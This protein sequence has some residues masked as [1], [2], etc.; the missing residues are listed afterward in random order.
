MPR[1]SDAV[2]AALSGISGILVTPFD[3]QDRPAPSRLK[4][5]VD[6]AIAAGVQ[7][8][9][10]NGNT[11]E[12]Y[13]L[14]TAEAETM[15]HA[16]AE[17][18]GGRVPL[19]AGVGRA[20]P[21]ALALAR[22]SAKAGADALMVHQP[23]DPFVAPRAVVEYVKRIGEAGGGLPI[24]LYLRN[25]AI[26]LDAI[27]ALCRVPGV[28]G[29]KWASQTP[30][31]LAAAIRRA[32]EGIAWVAGLAETWAPPLYAVGARGFTS[33]LINV[34]PAHSVAI[35]AALEKG[36][37][38]AAMTLIATMSA[39]EELRAEEGNGTN[40]SVVKAALALSGHDCGHVRA[41]GAWPLTAAQA[42][43]LEKLVAAWN[44]PR[45]AAA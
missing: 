33:G 9:V 22:A 12:F 32:P 1:S 29:V 5:V 30:M 28:I 4:P 31:R 20:L 40:V 39:F 43:K 27:E 26:G 13:A 23:P 11:S 2:R 37:Y 41:P 45:L 38:A 8:L 10:T 3:T 7:V 17:Q 15:V 6:R 19:L 36:D 35:H 42:G 34:W 44:L 21:D 14:T 24:V 25:D 16:A 18:V